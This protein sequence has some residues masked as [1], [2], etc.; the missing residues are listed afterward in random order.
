MDRNERAEQLIDD[1]GRAGVHLKFNDG[2][3]LVHCTV[4]DTERQDAIMGELIKLTQEVRLVLEFRAIRE[5]A[6]AFY[7]CKVLVQG[8]GEGTLEPEEAQRGVLQVTM[9]SLRAERKIQTRM[10]LPAADGFIFVDEG[11]D[12]APTSLLP[13][14]EQPRHR[15]GILELLRNTR[16]SSKDAAAR[17]D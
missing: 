8:Y 14:R 11:F 10:N 2:L 6:K 3:V 17:E 4:G 5:R 16:A 13:N 9:T 1:A 7:G 12:I 15:K